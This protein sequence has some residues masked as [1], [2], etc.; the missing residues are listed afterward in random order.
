M[1]QILFDTREDLPENDE[2]LDQP[3][4]KN[5]INLKSSLDWQFDL[6]KL[7]R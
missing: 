6:N 5:S 7:S 4:P 2:I 3:L 1:L